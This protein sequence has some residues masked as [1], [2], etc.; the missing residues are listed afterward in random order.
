MSAVQ[1]GVIFL[2]SAAL[3]LGVASLPL[4]QGDGSEKA[5]SKMQMYIIVMKKN[6]VNYTSQSAMKCSEFLEMI[7]LGKYDGIDSARRKPSV[8]RYHSVGIGYTAEL[9]N[10]AVKMVRVFTVHYTTVV[11]TW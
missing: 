8:G 11:G 4:Q 5:E 3:C 1:Q 9:D 10:V 2:V 6:A 7:S